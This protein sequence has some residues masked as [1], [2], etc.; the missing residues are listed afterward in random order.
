MLMLIYFLSLIGWNKP[1]I[2]IGTEN[3]NYSYETLIL[4]NQEKPKFDNLVLH[5]T[6]FIDFQQEKIQ[7]LVPENLLFLE[8]K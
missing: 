1:T 4:L 8:D 2:I 3:L 5:N 7:L 6:N